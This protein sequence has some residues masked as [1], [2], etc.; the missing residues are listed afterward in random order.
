MSRAA[1]LLVYAFAV[2]VL[3]AVFALY[4]QPQMMVA[5]GDLVWACFQ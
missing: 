2:A 5:L 3:L 1:R 4:T